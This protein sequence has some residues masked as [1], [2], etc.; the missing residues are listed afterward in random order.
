MVIIVNDALDE[1]KDAAKSVMEILSHIAPIECDLPDNVRFV[2]TSRPEYWADISKSKNLELAV[3]KQQFFATESCV[4]E[5]HSFIGARMREIKPNE[6]DWQDWPHPDQ[7]QRLS[8]KANSL[9]HYA[10]TTL[11]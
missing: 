9:F 4:S 8:D 10:V 2:I 6:P 5:V 1:L 7:L 3:F 11:Q